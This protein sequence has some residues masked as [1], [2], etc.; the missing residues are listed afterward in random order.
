[1]VPTRLGRVFVAALLAVFAGVLTQVAP[2]TNVA[3]AATSE[4]TP[5]ADAWV[6]RLNRDANYGTAKT[7]RSVSGDAQAVLRFRTEPWFGQPVTALTL[8]LHGVGGYAAALY[9][10][11][12][13]NSWKEST[14]TWRTRPSSIASL[15]STPAVTA[16]SVSFDLSGLFADGVVDRNVVAL[17]VGNSSADLATFGSRESA[18]APRLT[19]DST[20]PTAQPETL[21]ASGDTWADSTNKEKTHGSNR[22]L[23]VDGNPRKE[24]FLLFDVSSWR[25]SAYEKLELQLNVGTAGGPGFSVYRIGA[26]WSEATLTWRNRPTGGTLLADTTSAVNSGPLMVDLTAAFDSR[27]IEKGKLAVRIATTGPT[28]FD[29]SAREGVAPPVLQLTPESTTPPPS[30]TASPTVTPTASPTA[31]PTASPTATPTVTPTPT[32][33]A[34]PTPTPEPLFYF[35][36]RGTDHGVGMSQ[37]GARGRAT[38]GQTYDE[39]LSFYYTGVDFTTIDGTTPVRVLLSDDFIPTPTMPARVSAYLGSWQSEAFPGMTFPEGSYVE[40]WPPSPTPP[41]TPSPTPVTSPSATPTATPVPMA[42]L[43]AVAEVTASP[44]ST[45][46]ATPVTTPSPTPCV[47][48]TASATASAATEAF[49]AAALPAATATPTPTPSPQPTTTATPVASPTADPTPS[50]T[51]DTRWVATAFD[52]VGNVLATARTNDLFVEA[53]DADGVLEMRFRD[54]LPKYKLY[55]GRMRLLVT[56]TGLQAINILPMESYLRGVVPAEV[57]ATW[58]LEAVK[59]QA[60]AARTYAWSRLKGTAREWDVV[61]TAANQVY[62][63]Y[64]HEHPNSDRAVLG[65]QNIVLT[66]NGKVISALYH[67]AAGGHTENSEYAFVNDKGDPGTKVAYLR[68]KPDV[69]A[70]GVPYDINAGTYDWHSG[71]FTMTQLS[72]IMSNNNLTN[73]GTIYNMTFHRGVSGR[74]YKVVLEGSAG[75]KEVS[76]GKFKNTYNNFR[77]PGTP[78]MVSTL[79]FLTP[80]PQ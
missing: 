35:D 41:P 67:A 79:F 34:T 5:K 61:P 7:L 54:E 26:K 68:G 42:M 63:G 59:T 75:T 21:P 65:T 13:S 56:S 24:A 52:S 38:A 50:P 15:D 47:S 70:D 60:V 48:P 71:N 29:F 39:I 10:D 8:T 36:G 77:T 22:A 14:V 43:N 53:V 31:T 40:L 20:V 17:L 4:V 2:A 12:A 57:P 76:G 3:Y 58:P 6:N 72:Q 73:V 66:Y 51:P 9:V 23:F 46:S 19:L 11:Q 30:P 32:V 44:S 78:N 64:Q 18:T 62:G 33:C 49:I 69:D 45:S 27:T 25:G 74:V 1:M 55:R 28:A 16:T 37:Q 80:A